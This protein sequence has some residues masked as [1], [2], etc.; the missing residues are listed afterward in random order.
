MQNK[1][2]F[3]VQIDGNDV[4]F[5]VLRPTQA[6]GAK[7]QRVHSKAFRESV[8]SGAMV[9]SRIEKVMRDQNLWDDEKQKDYEQTY[10]RL[11]EG[12]KKLAKGG[13]KLSEAR[14]VAIQ[15]SIDRGAIRQLLANRNQL[16]Q[17]TAEAAAE[18]AK[19]NYLVSACTVFSDT[20]KSYFRDFEDY[21]NRENDPV[22]GPA[23]NLLAMMLY[24]VEEGHEKKLPESKFLLKYK[25]VREDLRLIDKQGQL[26][27]IKGRRV[28]EDG[29]LVNSEGQVVDAEGNLLTDTGEYKVEFQPFIDEDGKAVSDEPAAIITEKIMPGDAPIRGERA[30]VIIADEF[31][32]PEKLSFGAGI[33]EAKSEPQESLAV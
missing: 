16:D 9:R 8:E 25:F 19:F 7:A 11:L 3:K 6:V 32:E 28:N 18:N 4:E 29:N 1:K 24:D 21:Q 23:Q 12:E 14:E 22:A 15:M 2:T 26:I 30:S 5:A 33:M 17:H 31:E 20:G 10:K 27:D 13:I